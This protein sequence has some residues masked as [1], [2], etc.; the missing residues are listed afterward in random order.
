MPYKGENKELSI[1]F[2]GVEITMSS[3][4]D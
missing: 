4:Y 3:Q 2:K 1:N